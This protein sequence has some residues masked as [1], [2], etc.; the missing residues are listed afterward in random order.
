MIAGSD[1]PS[2]LDAFLTHTQGSRTHP[3][4]VIFAAMRLGRLARK[5]ALTNHLFWGDLI[6]RHFEPGY[7]QDSY[8]RA[9]CDLLWNLS[10]IF[11]RLFTGSSPDQ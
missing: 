3:G 1:A 5:A 6:A 8:L 10:C 7:H 9:L 4:L 2:A 11:F